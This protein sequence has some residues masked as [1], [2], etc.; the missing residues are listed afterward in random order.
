MNLC[1][2]EINEN[3]KIELLEMVEEIE[4]DVIEDKFEG[5]RN[6]KGLTSDNYND[7][8]LNLEKNKN[9][10]LYYPDRVDQTTFIL[11][12]DN[13]HIYGGTNLRHELNEGLLLHGGHIGYLIRPSERMKGYGS[14]ILKLVLV[15]CKKMGIDKALVTCREENIGSAKVIEK[16][17]GVYE[18]SKIN[19]DDNKTYRRYWIDV[20]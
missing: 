1:I 8:M 3:D 7:F 19:P 4:N 13:N 11:V 16:N 14:I 10:K 15:E 9:T 2:R 17:G 12:D 5:F 6:I 20:E 18:N